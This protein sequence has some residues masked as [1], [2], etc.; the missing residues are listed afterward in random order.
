MSTPGFLRTPDG[1]GKEKEGPKKKS[2]KNVCTTMP[3]DFLRRQQ[4][5][6]YTHL[7]P[8]TKDT[9]TPRHVTTFGSFLRITADVIYQIYIYPGMFFALVYILV[10]NDIGPLRFHIFPHLFS[11]A[12]SQLVKRF[13]KSHEST[14]V[15]RPGCVQT[16]AIVDGQANTTLYDGVIATKYCQKK[17]DESMPSGHALVG[18]ALFTA[19]MLSL[20]SGGLS[21]SP[22]GCIQQILLT[23]FGLYVVIFSSLHRVAFGYHNVSD[24][25]VGALIGML[26]GVAS[27]T[28][29]RK[30]FL[31]EITGMSRSNKI[32][33]SVFEK[34]LIGIFMVL[35]LYYTYV[36]ATRID[37]D[38]VV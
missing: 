7:F 25:I 32:F 15:C 29:F 16:D 20:W 22:R 5:Y 30:E 9:K 21:S 24:V 18:F 4:K 3:S 14:T 12:I 1:G 11:Y 36:F 23:L 31:M 6:A 37:D 33:Y 27:Y 10:T 19:A 2:K 34:V 35:G 8:Y 28:I 26:V 38:T 13:A 17:G